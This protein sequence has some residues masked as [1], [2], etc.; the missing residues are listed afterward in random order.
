MPA[1]VVSSYMRVK[2]DFIAPAWNVSVNL[3]PLC[4]L[5]R[6]VRFGRDVCRSNLNP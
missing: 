3:V 5:L 1:A 2:S 6:N 4:F